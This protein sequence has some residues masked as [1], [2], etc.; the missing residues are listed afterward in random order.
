MSE[1]SDYKRGVICQE[2]MVKIKKKIWWKVRTKKWI[3]VQD[4][5]QEKENKWWQNKICILLQKKLWR[6]QKKW[7]LMDIM[8]I[9][10]YLMMK[11]WKFICL[12]KIMNNI[13]KQKEKWWKLLMIKKKIWVWVL[14]KKKT[15]ELHLE[16]FILTNQWR[17]LKIHLYIHNQIVIAKKT[18]V[19]VIVSNKKTIP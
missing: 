9:F 1:M 14:K 10:I 17:D 5:H 12:A 13:W 7:A 18:K 2:R 16:T 15:W 19:F 6:K 4:C 11:R 8:N 3:K